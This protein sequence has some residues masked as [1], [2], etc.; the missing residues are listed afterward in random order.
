MTPSNRLST[1]LGCVC[2]NTLLSKGDYMKKCSCCK[3]EKDIQFFGKHKNNKDGLQY[4]CKNCRINSCKISFK[5]TSPEQLQK[6]NIATKIWKISNILKDKET[7]KQWRKENVAVR[8]NT[9]RKR[10]TA[11]LQRI[12]LWT[13]EEDKIHILCLYQLA[14]MRSKYSGEKWHVDH[15][16]PLQG[17]TVSGFH[18]PSNLQV[19]PAKDNLRKSNKYAT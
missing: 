6:R 16:I 4:Q 9:E 10:Q 1:R 19:I 18:T 5:K 11:K 13:T 8:T 14:A 15:V 7:A 2:L 12:P 3:E 17:K